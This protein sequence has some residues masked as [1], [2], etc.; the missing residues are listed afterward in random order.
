MMVEQY[1][2]Q[3]EELENEESELIL[4]ISAATEQGDHQKAD[5]LEDKLAEV[6][7]MMEALEAAISNCMAAPLDF[8]DDDDTETMD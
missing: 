1:E 7:I 5:R 4:S 2:V 3:L 8:S 6:L